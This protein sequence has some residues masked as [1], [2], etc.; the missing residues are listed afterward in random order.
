MY[1]SLNEKM[2]AG[3]VNAYEE[4]GFLPEWVSPVSN[5][6]Y[7]CWKC[8]STMIVNGYS[9]LSRSNC[10]FKYIKGIFISGQKDS[11]PVV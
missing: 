1:P 3:L 6:V 5:R 10:K 9:R 2:Q 4:S 11:A 8:S 7:T